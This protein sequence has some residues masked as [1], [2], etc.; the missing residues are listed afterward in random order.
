MI[1]MKEPAEWITQTTFF[2]TSRHV[3]LRDEV[4]SHLQLHQVL[5]WA[6]TTKERSLMQ[7]M[8]ATRMIALKEC[9]V[10]YSSAWCWSWL[11]AHGHQNQQWWRGRFWHMRI[12]HSQ[13][14]LIN[15]LML[16][17]N[18][19]GMTNLAV[20]SKRL[21]LIDQAIKN[22]WT[23]SQVLRSHISWLYKG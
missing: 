2:L 11:Q 3:I 18:S 5:V 16:S 17:Q 1:G 12:L 8:M 15:N 6:G 9:V 10:I 21:F 7:I 13:P 22:K 19:F 23:T 14:Y 4:K 20:I